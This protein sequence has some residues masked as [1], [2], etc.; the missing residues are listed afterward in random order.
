MIID[1][2]NRNVDLSIFCSERQCMVTVSGNMATLILL[3]EWMVWKVQYRSLMGIQQSLLSQG[4]ML[5]SLYYLF[6]KCHLN[7]SL[8][9]PPASSYLEQRTWLLGNPVLKAQIQISIHEFSESHCEHL[10]ILIHRYFNSL[11]LC[12]N[13]SQSKLESLWRHSEFI[14]TPCETEIHQNPASSAKLDSTI[15]TYVNTL[16]KK[17]DC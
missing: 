7:G 14:V 2:Q 15:R 10:V 16:Y 8:V 12:R 9:P 11:F 13:P 1:F 6:I 17:D 3:V 5:N 4:Q